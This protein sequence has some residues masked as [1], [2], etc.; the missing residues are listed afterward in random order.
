MGVWRTI[1]G[2]RVY[3]NDGDGLQ[4]AMAKSGKFSSGVKWDYR[5]VGEDIK[6]IED[7]VE[8]VKTYKQAVALRIA[9]DSQ[10][11][12]INRYQEEIRQG[13]ENGDERA[14]MTYRRRLR[15]AKKRLL[16]KQILG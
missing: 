4:T 10:E 15:T 13:L 16:D 2:R 14:L 5:G 7:A 3:I 9:I 12:V 1:S 8:T 6:K 11:N